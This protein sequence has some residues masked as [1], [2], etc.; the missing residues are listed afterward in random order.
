MPNA[1]AD[2]WVNKVAHKN[3]S[4]CLCW[5]IKRVVGRPRSVEVEALA[6]LDGLSIARDKG[7]Q[8][9][10]LESDCSQIVQ[11]LSRGGRTLESFGAVIDDCLMLKSYFQH[12][13]FHF[14]PRSNNMLAHR[15][16]T[17]FCSCL[18]DSSSPWR[19]PVLGIIY[20]L[21]QKKR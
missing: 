2:S 19:F 8:H 17:I 16:A 18:R 13:S 15:L 9:M 11:A 6:I 7:W 21:F 1:S 5:S 10:L 12:I 4:E 20:L 3:N 14:I